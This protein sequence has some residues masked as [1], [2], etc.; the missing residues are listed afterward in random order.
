MIRS[1]SV[2][3]EAA[4]YK[5][6][7]PHTAW[8]RGNRLLPYNLIENI[9][10]LTRMC[11]YARKNQNCTSFI[12]IFMLE[13]AYVYLNVR[14]YSKMIL[15]SSLWLH[16]RHNSLTGLFNPPP[17]SQNLFTQLSISPL[18]RISFNCNLTFLVLP[19]SP[20]PSPLPTVNLGWFHPISEFPH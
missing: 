1:F 7:V 9:S 12:W 13:H 11:A 6:S 20:T 5:S 10:Q 19:V 14:N 18:T 17:P 8:C 3:G 2:P 16:I 4:W 15:T